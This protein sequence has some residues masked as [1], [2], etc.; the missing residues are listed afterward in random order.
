MRPLHTPASLRGQ[1]TTFTPPHLHLPARPPACPL[2]RWWCRSPQK[3]DRLASDRPAPHRPAL[4]AMPMTQ[5][6]NTNHRL[7][8]PAAPVPKSGFFV[9]I[10][11]ICWLCWCLRLAT[12]SYLVP[13]TK[14]L[15]SIPP[16]SIS[17]QLQ[18]PSLPFCQRWPA[19]WPGR[20]VD[21]THP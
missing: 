7:R 13:I 16:P 17:P 12:S 8:P 5:N 3:H 19:A 15:E 10:F 9:V 1:A 2:P 4:F 11:L 6:V 14:P 20:Q 21:L 18:E